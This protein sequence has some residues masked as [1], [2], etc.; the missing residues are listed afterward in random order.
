MQTSLDFSQSQTPEL[1]SPDSF[2]S[3]SLDSAMSEPAYLRFVL[4]TVLGCELKGT[5]RAA[6]LAIEQRLVA[7]AINEADEVTL[8]VIADQYLNAGDELGELACL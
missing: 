7:D 5:D 6:M 8:F 1:S 4:G 3:E 2:E